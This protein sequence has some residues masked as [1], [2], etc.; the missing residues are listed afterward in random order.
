MREQLILIPERIRELREVLEVSREEMAGKINVPY[1]IYEKYESGEL[2]I[3]I[4]AMY[5]IASVLKVDMTLLLT[6]DAPRLNA[7]SVC[8]KNEG[9]SIDR[10]KGYSYVS[11]G[12][13]FKNRIME[14]LLVTLNEATE[15]AALVTHGGQEF[16][17]VLKG[18][19]KVVHGSHEYILNEGDTIYFDPSIKHGQSAV[20]GDAQFLTVILE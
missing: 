8:R 3:P 2:D 18:K 15:A 7:A 4:S 12:Y 20:G 11:L 5:E 19:V 10:F 1:E 16:N 13:N 14:P 6:G 9:V 17:Y